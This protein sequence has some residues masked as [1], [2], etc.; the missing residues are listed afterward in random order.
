LT[1]TTHASAG[2]PEVEYTNR[3]DARR[4]LA[5]GRARLDRR[6]SNLRLVVFGVLLLTAWFTLG[7]RSL[8]LAWLVVPAATFGALLLVHDRVIRQRERAERA[9][10]FYERGLARIEHRFAGTG[11]P[12]EAYRDAQHPYAEDLDLF[13]SGSLFE[14]LCMARTRAGEETLASWLL[15]PASAETARSRQAAVAE[16]RERLDLRE[17]LALLGANVRAHL[18]VETLRSWGEAPGVLEGRLHYWLAAMLVTASLGALVGWIWGG[19]GPGL[20]V[21]AL[22]IQGAYALSLRRRVLRVIRGVDAPLRDLEIFSQLLERFEAEPLE[23]GR[24]R[25]LRASLETAGVPPSRRIA[26]LHRLVELL[27]ARRN[28]FFAP[29]GALLLWSSQLALRIEHWRQDVGPNLAEW[30]E[31]VGEFEALAS[32]AGHAFEHP[33]HPFPDLVESAEPLFE[34]TALGHPLIDPASRVCND[35]SLGGELRAL[36]VSGSNMSGKSTLLR[37]VGVNAVLAL[38][39]APVCARELRLSPLSVGA[40][41]RVVDSLQHGDS[42]FYA[43]IK[44]IRRVMELAESGGALFL[45]DEIFHGTNSHDRGIGAEAVVKGLIERHAIGLVTTHDLALA[46]VAER[47]SPSTGNVH[48][49][50]HLEDGR[51]AFDYRMRPGVVEKSNALELMRAVGLPV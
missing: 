8:A 3:R 43:E 51:I 19:L 6:I 35:L 49:Q 2:T 41:I 29:I 16:L 47:L 38:A 37:T 30:V 46:R 33:D 25:A 5:G 20:P 48:F 14:L 23:S 10:A 7:A 44:R 32:L 17:D 18:H 24:L 13:G 26:R 36:V 28:Q 31:A 27:D 50:D 21:L 11:E 40:S 45:L 22:G 15:E 1:S 42:H 4:E 9:V 39:G 12:G 34:A